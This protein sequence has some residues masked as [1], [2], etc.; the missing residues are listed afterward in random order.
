MYVLLVFMTYKDVNI[1][2]LDYICIKMYVYFVM[3]L[4]VCLFRIAKRLKLS[5]KKNSQSS[6]T[7]TMNRLLNT[8][9]LKIFN[10]KQLSVM[11]QSLKIKLFS[12]SMTIMKITPST[13]KS[14]T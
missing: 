14:S 2:L 13:V 5:I 3:Y 6:A 9:A 4:T 1:H 10:I 11:V 8:R 7:L 12:I